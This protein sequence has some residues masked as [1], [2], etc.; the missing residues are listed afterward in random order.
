MVNTLKSVLGTGLLAMPWALL[1]LRSHLSIAI[2]LC[3]LLGLWSCYTMALLHDCTVLAWPAARGY[4]EL[5]TTALGP[6]G[7]VVCAVNLVLHQI[8]CTASYLVFIGDSL[9]DV[10]GGSAALYIA[11]AAP[12]VVLLCWLRDV[13]ALSP[14]S[15]VGTAALVVALIVIVYHLHSLSTIVRL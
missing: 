4:S 1:Q 6:P 3:V 12:P 14:A 10:F 15:A 11:S 2:S 5:V 13:R 7:G 8:L 9:Q